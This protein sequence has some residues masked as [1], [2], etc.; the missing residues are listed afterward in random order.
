ML[1]SVENLFGLSH[2][3]FAGAPGLDCFGNDVY[4]RP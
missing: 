1:C 3:G 2:L 4:A